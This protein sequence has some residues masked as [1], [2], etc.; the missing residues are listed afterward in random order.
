MKSQETKKK[1]LRCLNKKINKF[2]FDFL[3]LNI[4]QTLIYF[5]TTA[6]SYIKLAKINH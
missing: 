2:D 6:R 5:P 3:K 1:P 4:S